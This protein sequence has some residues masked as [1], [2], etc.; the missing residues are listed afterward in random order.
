PKDA[1]RQ[2]QLAA[3]LHA[4]GN[5]LRDT[6]QPADAQEAYQEAL[7]IRRQVA[8]ESPRV[9]RYQ[10]DL[11]A[12]YTQEGVRQSDEARAQEAMGHPVEA[13]DCRKKALE[14]YVKAAAEQ[15]K[16][17]RRDP[18]E[19]AYRYELAKSFFNIAVVHGARADAARRR[20]NSWPPA[21]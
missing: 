6:D 21:L 5:A 1:R 15:E 8:G 16:L 19:P 20:T 17:V 7:K 2:A 18:D 13:E 9:G 3:A 10:L 4:L 14:W 12:S 11:A